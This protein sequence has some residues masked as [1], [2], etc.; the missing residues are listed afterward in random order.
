MNKQLTLFEKLTPLL[1]CIQNV[2]LK[3][4]FKKCI[5]EKEFINTLQ[6][7]EHTK[8]IDLVIQLFYSTQISKANL[9]L[10]L[11]EDMLANGYIRHIPSPTYPDVI[12]E[13]LYKLLTANFPKTSTEEYCRCLSTFICSTFTEMH[14]VQ[15][16]NTVSKLLSC[17]QTLYHTNVVTLFAAK[18]KSSIETNSDIKYKDV[19][20]FMRSIAYM[21]SKHT[22]NSIYY[23]TL[24]IT[25]CSE[26]IKKDSPQRV[27]NIIDIIS[28]ELGFSEVIDLIEL[29]RCI[30]KYSLFQLIPWLGICVKSV[31]LNPN[32]SAIIAINE[33]ISS[34]KLPRLFIY[35][36]Y[37]INQFDIFKNIVSILLQLIN[38][39]DL[40]ALGL[41]AE[42][43][44]SLS[45]FN[46]DMINKE[47]YYYDT[48]TKHQSL[49]EQIKE[50][51]VLF[52][53]KGFSGIDKLIQIGCISSNAKSIAR[54]LMS[55]ELS[56][57]KVGNVLCKNNTLCKECLEEYIMNLDLYDME[58][59][60]AMRR[61]FYRFQMVG[62]SQI[63]GRVFE[64]FS[65]RY[66][67][68]NI[69]YKD[70]LTEEKVEQFSTTL[71]IL[72]TESH[73]SNVK[74]KVVDTF[75]KF[76]NIICKDFQIQYETKELLQMYRRVQNTPFVPRSISPITRPVNILNEPLIVQPIKMTKSIAFCMFEI[77]WKQITQIKNFTTIHSNLLFT[78]LQ[79]G[80]LLERNEIKE[81]GTLIE[82]ISNS[83]LS[84]KFT[85]QDV[86]CIGRVIISMSECYTLLKQAWEPL[87]S[88]VINIKIIN[89]ARDINSRNSFKIN[90]RKQLREPIY[91]LM[92]KINESQI[93]KI[94]L[95]HLATVN[96]PENL[97][98]MIDF[99]LLEQTLQ[100]LEIS[101][102]VVYSD[103][104]KGLIG[105]IKSRINDF[106]IIPLQ[107]LFSS[108]SK[109]YLRPLN[110][111]TEEILNQ[112]INCFIA[113]SF[114]PYSKVSYLSLD[115][116]KQVIQLYHSHYNAFIPIISDSQDINIRYKAL[117]NLFDCDVPK[118]EV[119]ILYDSLQVI[120][121]I[122]GD[123]VDLALEKIVYLFLN[124]PH[125]NKIISIYSLLVHETTN[126]NLLNPINQCII[127]F[128]KENKVN[129]LSLQMI[130]VVASKINDSSV[131][132]ECFKIIEECSEEINGDLWIN[133]LLN[134]RDEHWIKTIFPNIFMS[135]KMKKWK[136]ELVSY[137]LFILLTST[138][139]I[140]ESIFKLL[141]VE[142][143]ENPNIAVQFI[144]E[145]SEYI[146]VGVVDNSPKKKIINSTYDNCNLEECYECK[147]KVNCLNKQCVYCQHKYCDKCIEKFNSHQCKL[148]FPS[149]SSLAKI[150]IEINKE[151]IEYFYRLCSALLR[152]SCSE[153]NIFNCLIKTIHTWRNLYLNNSSIILRDNIIQKHYTKL[154]ISLISLL[155]EIGTKEQTDIT[156]MVIEESKDILILFVQTI[157]PS[158][159][160]PEELI[161]TLLTKVLTISSDE[162]FKEMYS[163]TQPYLIETILT[164]IQP[165]RKVI[166]EIM[167]RNCQFK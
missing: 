78:T 155:F 131:G 35:G 153:L 113:C 80:C 14:G 5:E 161:L 85:E 142:F 58:L 37:Q 163:I 145:L 151:I 67:Q 135:K 156:S 130:A 55:D 22:E 87:L 40:I 134:S 129:T 42:I 92:F 89:Q 112:I 31:S 138:K 99:S 125:Q 26:E 8:F 118:S 50:C 34:E 18:Y 127:Q 84:S 166:A 72:A 81:I 132:K 15:L 63:V 51:V 73:N 29:W 117:T 9:L 77:V 133:R 141:E 66:L 56:P 164:N 60:Q 1:N 83:D 21:I 61:L 96:D 119:D 100:T 6:D 88:I 94:D 86:I 123:V 23:L 139:E 12:N 49:K 101:E 70:I 95:N 102:D 30:I 16:Q 13:L 74:L 105:V 167:K 106:P 11:I 122:N 120:P 150:D 82:K 148:T 137:S 93:Q 110:S 69:K 107:Y 115:Y 98:K 75:E 4:E 136:N 43:M 24:F 109:N 144:N 103:Y 64:L 116:L 159:Y 7:G 59:D 19:I 147:C 62:E 57:E 111:I 27:Q 90:E 25:Q 28:P 39:N 154:Y 71:L 2:N 79:T 45:L 128:I 68:C 97:F 162:L 91:N 53:Q 20:V 108:A 160:L 47:N 10:D 38:N 140:Q 158:T 149:L 121:D 54:F 3:N 32:K 46:D 44:R 17:K 76:N 33:T 157:S 65:K 114:H 143:Q 146:F 36:D 48:F 152:S 52:N 126:I 41:L 104:I 124:Y 165:I